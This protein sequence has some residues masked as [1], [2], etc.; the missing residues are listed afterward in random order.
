MVKF[1][2][3]NSD[4]I[5]FLERCAC[6]GVV[7]VTSSGKITRN[8]FNYFYLNVEDTELVVKAIDSEERKM[9]I[10]HFL[11]DVVVQEKGV[12]AITDVDT[13]LDTL[14]AIP[15][16]LE[17]SFVSDKDGITIETVDST[18]YYG[19]RLRQI[20]PD[21]NIQA[22]LHKSTIGVGRWDSIHSFEEG[23]PKVS[24][25]NQSAFYNTRIDFDKRE[26]QKVI[27]DSVKL[28]HDQDITMTLSN[29]SVGFSSGKKA[30][31]IRAEVT[32]QKE[33][34]NPIKTTKIITNLHPIVGHLFDK[35]VFFCRVA[36]DDALKFWIQSVSN[37]IELNFC[38]GS[39]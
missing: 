37:N 32:F 9:Y 22:S 17:I 20:A 11:R 30:D 18:V 19:F 2:I 14:K 12:L 16:Q 5:T 38:S 34:T 15:N 35:I 29:G 28:T 27:D 8:F 24:E 3:I 4:L 33:M 39:V 1:R 26:L 7:L 36:S 6:K 10:R 23:F 13:L 25:D 21:E 31:N